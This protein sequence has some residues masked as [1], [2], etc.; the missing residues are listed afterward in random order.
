MRQEGIFRVNGN[1]K[2]IEKLKLE[3]DTRKYA[4]ATLFWASLELGLGLE[5]RLVLRVGLRVGVRLVLEC[6][7]PL[8]KC[9]AGKI[10]LQ[11]T[12]IITHRSSFSRNFATSLILNKFIANW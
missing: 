11:I 4:I 8:S 7:Q 1:A 10:R 6:K 2:V 3:F 12:F 5:L 9:T